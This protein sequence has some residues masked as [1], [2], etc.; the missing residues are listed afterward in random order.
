MDALF[1]CRRTLEW[2]ASEWS[3]LLEDGTCILHGVWEMRF[4]SSIIRCYVQTQ[5]KCILTWQTCVRVFDAVMFIIFAV[6]CS[7]AVCIKPEFPITIGNLLI[8]RYQKHNYH[9]RIGYHGKQE[10]IAD[11]TPNGPHLHGQQDLPIPSSLLQQT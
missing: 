8:P 4:A 11:N 5:F 7:L 10:F 9:S 3:R 6:R 2:W 1:L